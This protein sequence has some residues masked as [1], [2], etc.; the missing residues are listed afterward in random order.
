MT[1]TTSPMISGPHEADG[2]VDE[3][4]FTFKVKGSDHLKIIVTDDEDGTNPVEYTTG[5]TLADEYLDKDA[6]G[7]VVFPSSGDPVDDGKFVWVLGNVPYEQ[8]VLLTRQGAYNPTLV[9]AGLDALAIQNKQTSEMLSR[10]V[11]AP[12]GA[13][14]PT[15]AEVAAAQE[16]AER[17]EAAA[18]NSDWVNAPVADGT[19]SVIMVKDGDGDIKAFP[20]GL[21]TEVSGVER[22][23]MLNQGG[24]F[25]H[26]N[27][28]SA[29]V[30]NV[31]HTLRTQTDLQY[32]GGAAGVIS[33]H[34][35]SM[36]VAAGVVTFAWAGLDVLRSAATGGQNV[37]RYAQATKEGTGPVWALVTEFRD[38]T[39]QANPTGGSYSQ[40]VDLVANGTDDNNVRRGI[41]IIGFRYNAAGADVE[42]GYGWIIQPGASDVGH[43][44][45]KRGGY[46]KGAFG[47]GIDAADAT[48]TTAF[49]KLP[50][51][52]KIQWGD[53][54]SIR[55]ETGSFVFRNELVGGPDVFSVDAAGIVYA[56]GFSPRAG[57]TTQAPIQFTAGTN[58]TVT[59]AGDMEYDGKAIYF[60][61]AAASRGVVPSDQIAVLVAD[62]A[63][64]DVNTAQAIFPSANDAITLQANVTYEF[65]CLVRFTR[66]AGTTSH[67][68]ALQFGGGYFGSGGCDARFVA[69]ASSGIAGA[70]NAVY[71]IPGDT[72]AAVT[73]TAASTLV[74]EE[75]IIHA[76]GIFRTTTSNTMVP[77][78]MYSVAPGGAPTFKKGSFFKVHPI[79]SDTVEAVGNWS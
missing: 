7:V 23:G 70:L 27:L 66:S 45:F 18:A 79:G 22:N 13:D 51:T 49:A 55:V 25:L 3:W 75:V 38:N 52:A 6:G 53:Y 48:F 31:G 2:V 17:A 46:L 69:Q 43:V 12:V 60:S 8:D 47:V 59:E 4:D 24:L 21:S 68:T 76:K 30:V 54:W 78:I 67:T 16:Y 72:V 61:P 58:E 28:S 5:Y 56:N 35:N 63:G 57:T 37:A 33:G 40:E 41:D 64:A 29:P 77:Q 65:E 50:A 1:V 73:V 71:Q 36:Y 34:H 10:A 9:M 11:I 20:L 19:M 15:A 32:T 39:E 42:F 14:V 44:K 74:N 26:E 62:R